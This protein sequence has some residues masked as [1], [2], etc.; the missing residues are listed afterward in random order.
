M[1]VSESG[2][3][4]VVKPAS[5]ALPIE[6]PPGLSKLGSC[7]F[8]ILTVF[9]DCFG[10]EPVKAPKVVQP[11][12]PPKPEVRVINRLVKRPFGPRNLRLSSVVDPLNPLDDNLPSTSQAGQETTPS[13]SGNLDGSSDQNEYDTD[14]LTTHLC[15]AF[16]VK[17]YESVGSFAREGLVLSGM[18]SRSQA[19]RKKCL[20]NGNRAFDERFLSTVKK[21]REKNAQL[22]ED[23]LEA[24][25]R[26]LEADLLSDEPPESPPSVGSSTSSPKLEQVLKAKISIVKSEA[27]VPADA[28][29]NGNGRTFPVTRRTDRD[30][31]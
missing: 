18:L 16:D 3:A 21:N 5:V 22:E 29:E 8:F 14:M 2:S 9:R 31:K 17:G 23:K 7:Q 4:C 6:L 10:L 12:P 27:S 30:R 26:A 20:E 11:A 15:R 19:E 24:E 25:A 28:K 13:T 1:S